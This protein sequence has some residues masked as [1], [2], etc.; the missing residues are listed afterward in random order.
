MRYTASEKLEII[1]LVEQSTLPVRRTL[2]QL[3]IPKSTFYGWYRR[4][5]EGG[6]DAL[7]D[8][9]PQPSRVW[10]KVADETAA[11]IVELALTE[12]A[13]APRELAVKYTDTKRYYV[14]ESTVYRPRRL[15]TVHPDLALVYRHGGE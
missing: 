11:A 12:A 8:Q 3:T 10:N 14:S 1:Q 4:Y 2:R 5:V 7:K 6:L 9:P 13:L 15:L